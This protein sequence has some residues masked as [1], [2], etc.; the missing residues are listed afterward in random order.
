MPPTQ[1]DLKDIHLPEAIAWWPPALGWWILA[2]LIPLLILMLVKI[3]QHLTRKTAHKTAK[4]MLADIKQDS[5]KDN[6]QKLREL[7]VLLRRVAISVSPKEDVAGLT[8]RAWLDFLDSSLTG[9]PFAEGVGACLASETYRKTPLAEIEITQLISLC[10]AWLKAQN[11][12]SI[13]PARA[14]QTQ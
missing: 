11:N 5:S 12:A 4:K 6:F 8:G 10:E 13:K 2:V 9:A 1:L 14:K 3:Y 7:S